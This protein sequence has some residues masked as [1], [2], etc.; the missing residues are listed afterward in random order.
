[1]TTYAEVKGT[2]VIQYPYDIGCM[3]NENPFTNFGPNPDIKAIFQGTETALENGY[4]LVDVRLLDQPEVD[5]RTEKAIRD[6]A[7]SV[8]GG[9]WQ[10]GWTVGAKS[11]EEI[12]EADTS[13]RDQVRVERNRLLSDSD[14]TQLVDAPVPHIKKTM[15]LLENKGTVSPLT[16]HARMALPSSEE[17]D[18]R[19]AD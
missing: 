2:T 15:L 1:M 10:L 11:F 16:G 14:W 5:E 12:E 8:Q 17:T 13:M 9:E 4:T 6:K 19:A 7:P 3:Q 18:E